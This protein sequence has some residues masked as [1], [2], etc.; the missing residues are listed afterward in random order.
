LNLNHQNNFIIGIDASRNRS[1]GA[2]AHL[3]GIL[4]Y[5]NPR[6]FGITHIHLW[7]YKALLDQ[8]PDR[9]WLIKHSPKALD[10]SLLFQLIWQLFRL[11]RELKV[12]KC[13]ILF[14]T[15]ASSLASF[16]PMVVLS[17]D[18]LSYESGIL[19]KFG[20]GM[21]RLRLHLI[22]Y[23]QNM[24]FR[25]AKGV[26][27]L[28]HYASSVIQQHCGSLKKIKIVPHGVHDLFK[29]KMFSCRSFL[30]NSEIKC[31]YVSPISIY[32]NQWKVIEAI[33]YLREQGFKVNLDI[34][35]YD[36]GTATAIVDKYLSNSAFSMNYIRIL[37]PVENEKLPDILLNADIFIFASTCENLPVTLLEA[38]AVGI[39]IASS[40][41]GPM[42]EVLDNGGLYFN[43]DDHRSIASSIRQLIVDFE[44][45]KRLSNQSKLLASQYS[46]RRCSAETFSFICGNLK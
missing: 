46:W 39:P 5:L 19:E 27:F 7:S 16:S 17:Q 21:T 26:I 18:M 22:Y 38:M 10:S 20:F 32:K 33:D 23:L 42:P 34:I 44:L 43:P 11:K 31:I 41:R 13:D 15:D 30:K 9:P 24:T 35:G 40:D 1:G 3:V 28:T 2:V 37:G 6:E 8:L 14:T 12:H 29:E 4:N 36:D 25:K 45:R